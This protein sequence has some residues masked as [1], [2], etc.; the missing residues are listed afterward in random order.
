[1]P[2]T[3]VDPPTAMIA[4]ISEGLTAVE[5]LHG[6]S[7]QVP[8]YPGIVTSRLSGTA[9]TTTRPALIACEINDSSVVSTP[10]AVIDKL[11]TCGPCQ[12][13]RSVL[14]IHVRAAF[15]APVLEGLVQLWPK[16]PL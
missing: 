11:I 9:A 14:M 8:P 13:N 7:P 5:P 4:G 10:N 16:F 3:I 6:S 1:M 2:D 12:L 15:S